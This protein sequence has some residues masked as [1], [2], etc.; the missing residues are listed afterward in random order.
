M[1]FDGARAVTRPLVSGH[2]SDVIY[3]SVAAGSSNSLD[4][5]YTV[6]D[7][8]GRY[9]ALGGGD[10]AENASRDDKSTKLKLDEQNLGFLSDQIEKLTTEPAESAIARKFEDLPLDILLYVMKHTDIDDQRSLV[11]S[12]EATH[13][14]WKS[15][16]EA[17][18]REVLEEQFREFE[19][20]FGDG[21]GFNR[22]SSRDLKSPRE[23][24][25]LD[26]ANVNSRRSS[27]TQNL[28]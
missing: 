19:G 2:T 9:T 22:L 5:S 25:H 6:T 24:K 4:E 20:W 12:S 16:K 7:P 8:K 11:L 14:V 27:L 18:F 23:A 28:I 26:H 13:R 3:N 15:C 21:P 10:P 17:I 1:P